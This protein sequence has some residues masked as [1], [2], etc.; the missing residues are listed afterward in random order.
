LAKPLLI[1]FLFTIILVTTSIVLGFWFYLLLGV[2]LGAVGLCVIM[3]YIGDYEETSVSPSTQNSW[4]SPRI[5]DRQELNL[6]ARVQDEW[7]RQ[8]KLGGDMR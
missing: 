5:Q 1:L 2:I 6:R 7:D 4:Q 8:E 3:Y